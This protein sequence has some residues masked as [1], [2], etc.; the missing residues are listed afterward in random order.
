MSVTLLKSAETHKQ[1][2]QNA[3]VATWV[4]LSKAIVLRDD[5]SDKVENLEFKIFPLGKLHFLINI[6]RVSEK[7]SAVSV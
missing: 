1:K 2:P 6:L 7:S 5:L 4:I 3:L